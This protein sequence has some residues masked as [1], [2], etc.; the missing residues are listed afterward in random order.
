M[1]LVRVRR[2]FCIGCGLCR[3]QCEAHHAGGEDV[4]KVLKHRSAPALGGIRIERRDTEC[5]SVR[6]Q[7]CI[8]APCVDACL[9]GAMHRDAATGLVL[10]QEDKCV[11]CGTCMVVCPFGAIR[12]DPVSGKAV[13]CDGCL[14]RDVPRCVDVCPTGALISVDVPRETTTIPAGSALHP[15]VV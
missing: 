8:D 1:R 12:T 13:K 11:G 4:A 9:T 15:V 3:V 5:M 2:E 14:D 6:C 7:H 10:V